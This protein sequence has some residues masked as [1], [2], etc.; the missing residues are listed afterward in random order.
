MRLSP[1]RVR[2][3]RRNQTQPRQV[4]LRLPVQPRSTAQLPI[5]LT[6][7]PVVQ[8]VSRAVMAPCHGQVHGKILARSLCS[9]LAVGANPAIACGCMA[10]RSRRKARVRPISAALAA[11]P[12][13]LIMLSMKDPKATPGWR[14]QPMA[15]TINYWARCLPNIRQPR[16]VMQFQPPISRLHSGYALWR[17][18]AMR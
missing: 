7:A 9:L 1:L 18:T 14:S 17:R 3:P 10:T 6:M 4:L 15:S 2:L 8:R 16:K 11:Q 5:I 13:P 12:S